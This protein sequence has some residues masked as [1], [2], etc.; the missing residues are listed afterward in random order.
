MLMV[1]SFSVQIERI[2]YEYRSN[3][4]LYSFFDELFPNQV[5]EGAIAYF[6][7]T[8]SLDIDGMI[9]FLPAIGAQSTFGPE[10]GS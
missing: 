9:D 10:T 4:A 6:K 1:Q 3:L 7:Q 2:P 8:V 5:S